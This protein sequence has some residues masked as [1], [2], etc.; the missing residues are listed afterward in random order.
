MDSDV[1]VPNPVIPPPP[2]PPRFDPTAPRIATPHLDRLLALQDSFYAILRAL[3]QVSVDVRQEFRDTDPN[4]AEVRRLHEA[5]GEL[6]QEGEALLDRVWFWCTGM[7]MELDEMLA[8]P[9][10]PEAA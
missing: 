1:P 3:E 7:G 9:E 2:L 5:I 10:P 6:V 8:V 4:P